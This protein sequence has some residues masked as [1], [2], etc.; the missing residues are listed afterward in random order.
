MKRK[1]CTSVFW[2]IPF[3]AQKKGVVYMFSHVL[4]YVTARS[5]LDDYQ[6]FRIM[7][8]GKSCTARMARFLCFCLGVLVTLPTTRIYGPLQG[9]TSNPAQKKK[10]EEKKL[11]ITQKTILFL[12]G[13]F[14]RKNCHP[15]SFLILG[16]LNSTRALQSSTF[17]ISG[18]VP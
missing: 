7:L 6:T 15:L 2:L 11:D 14:L 10:K 4:P 5:I 16:V 1:W 13:N 8:L 9:H 17:Q 12:M 18:G 3:K